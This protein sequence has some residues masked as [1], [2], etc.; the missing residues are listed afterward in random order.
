M[1]RWAEF[2]AGAPTAELINA[3]SDTVRLLPGE[4]VFAITRPSDRYIDWKTPIDQLG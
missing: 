1:L 4:A 3:G 2:F